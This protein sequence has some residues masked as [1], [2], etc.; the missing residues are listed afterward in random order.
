MELNHDHN[1]DEKAILKERALALSEPLESSENS[2][3]T[4]EVTV[5]RLANERY[6]I[7]TFYIE[8]VHILRDYTMIPCT[9]DYVLGIMNVRGEIISV[10]DLRKVFDLPVKEVNPLNKVLIIKDKEMKFGILTEVIE[11]VKRIWKER[12]QANLPTL[13]NIRSE[14]LKGITEDRLIVLDGEKLLTGSKLV[15]YEEV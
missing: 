2:E 3:E 12:L 7:E 13:T 1:R 5:F 4:V 6:G 11:G 14:Y 8:E 9:P 15:V 10:I